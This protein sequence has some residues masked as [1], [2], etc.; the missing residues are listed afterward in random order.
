MKAL[1]RIL[2]LVVLF[3]LFS[4]YQALAKDKNTGDQIYTIKR[5]ALTL[6]VE[7]YD[8]LQPELEKI[9]AS[10]TQAVNLTTLFQNTPRIA[11]DK[12]A[13]LNRRLALAKG[14]DQKNLLQLRFAEDDMATKWLLG[15]QA[16][17]FA[18]QPAGSDKSWRSIPALDQWGNPLELAVNETP[19]QPVFVIDIDRRA[20]VEA[21][22]RMM[23]QVFSSIQHID[24]GQSAANS[25]EK[26]LNDADVDAMATTTL[27][28]TVLDT[29]SLN[30]DEEPWI[31]G[32]AE[33]YALITGIDPFATQA[34]IHA[35]DMPYLDHDGTTYHPN[36]ILFF[37][38]TFRFGAAD[39]LLMEDDDG[40]NYQQLAVSLLNIA[41]AALNQFGEPTIAAIV[42]IT[43]AVIAA[44]PSSIF[45]DDD[46]YV[47]VFYTIR[48]GLSYSSY[49]GVSGNARVTMSPLIL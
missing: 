32:S 18:I 43:N 15:G 42:A 5:S 47:D 44:L 36:Q 9:F 2:T 49:Y 48:E 7:S 16:P 28:T 10:N 1:S 24:A 35:I 41:E 19:T 12:V 13:S 34:I 29:I 22:I 23:E 25:V 20:A 11:Q 30:N 33:I 39:M 6:L 31:K 26:Q 40:T 46:D 45:V 38:D 17:L 37:W 14:V 3:G 27:S 8:E 4:T 21:G